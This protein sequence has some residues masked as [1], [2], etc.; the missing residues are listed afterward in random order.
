MSYFFVALGSRAAATHSAKTQSANL[1][2]IGGAG[3]PLASPNGNGPI[4]VR[5]AATPLAPT[6]SLA[7]V[8]VSALSSGLQAHF[9]GILSADTSKID[10][11]N[12][13]NGSALSAFLKADQGILRSVNIIPTIVSTNLNSDGSQTVSFTAIV[14]V[15]PGTW[16]TNF[17]TLT[18]TLLP[19]GRVIFPHSTI[20]TLVS[21]LDSKCSF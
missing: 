17:G 12:A 20:C 1:Q 16:P 9:N 4:A 14:K 2:P 11:D 21:P 13:T 7:G 10:F 15:G 18:A 19:N 8:S 6:S 3:A 5:P